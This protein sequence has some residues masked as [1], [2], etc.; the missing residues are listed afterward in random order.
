M[1]EDSVANR[2]AGT[3]VVNLAP[4]RDLWLESPHADSDQGTLAQGAHQ[5]LGLGARAYLITGSHRCASAAETPCSGKSNMCGG[6][7][8]RADAAHYDLTFFHS[9]HRALRYAFP[10][11]V[12][13]NVHGMDVDG[14]EA[15]VISNGTKAPQPGSLSVR[16]RDALNTRL[17]EN[18]RAFSCNDP[19]DE[20]QHRP[21]CGT[22]NVQGRAD[23]G[24]SDACRA[25]STTGGDRFLH[26]EQAASLRSAPPGDPLS[27]AV[28]AALADVV[29][30][31]LGGAGLGCSEAAVACR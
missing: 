16:F 26:L 25:A 11:A 12:A 15:A 1:F 9:A 20:G 30:C 4:G 8:R 28:I 21:L 13:V 17:P 22:T 31:T 7:L 10:S 29:P 24:S 23:N 5:L 27:D 3:F 18:L 2:G 19:N 14:V 6:K